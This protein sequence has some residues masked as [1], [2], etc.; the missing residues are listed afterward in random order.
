MIILPAR[1]SCHDY[2][3]SGA[4]SFLVFSIMHLSGLKRSLMV[5]QDQPKFTTVYHRL[6]NYFKVFLC[7]N[8]NYVLPLFSAICHVSSHLFKVSNVFLDAFS[9]FF[10]VFYGFS[11]FSNGFSVSTFYPFFDLL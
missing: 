5:Y 7:K 8:V 9:S 11:Q 6:L 10:T 2:P 3:F 4:N 1:R